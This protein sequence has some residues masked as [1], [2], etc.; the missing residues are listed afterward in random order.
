MLGN[1]RKLEL[2]SK[3]LVSLHGRE[4]EKAYRQQLLIFVLDYRVIKSDGPSLLIVI[5][6]TKGLRLGP[7]R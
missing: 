6:G 4:K 7:V 1:W 5:C 3:R 2:S